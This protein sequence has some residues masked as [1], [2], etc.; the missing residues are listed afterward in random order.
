MTPV[1]NHDLLTVT[2]SRTSTTSQSCRRQSF[3][4][5]ETRSAEAV[6]LQLTG[7]NPR[8]GLLCVKRVL[9]FTAKHKRI[10]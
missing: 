1:A 2:Q 3:E 10:F 6:Q 5:N 9:Y 8:R 4:R 7:F